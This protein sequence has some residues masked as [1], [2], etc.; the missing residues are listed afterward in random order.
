MAQVISKARLS[1]TGTPQHQISIQDALSSVQN[2][3]FLRGKVHSYMFEEH[4]SFH[5]WIISLQCSM[6]KNERMKNPDGLR[7]VQ[8]VAIGPSLSWSLCTWS[9]KPSMG[10]H[11]PNTFSLNLDD[12]LL[13]KGVFSKEAPRANQSS[14]CSSRFSSGDGQSPKGSQNIAEAGNAKTSSV[15]S[16]LPCVYFLLMFLKEACPPRSTE[17]P[18]THVL[19]GPWVVA[20]IYFNMLRSIL[21]FLLAPIKYGSLGDMC[22]CL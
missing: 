18:A 12:N 4:P 8:R 10:D 7:V 15:V 20:G 3:P 9:P 16:F 5:P 21:V 19:N 17:P 6:K 14:F 11:G 13:G 22:K 1:F 2:I